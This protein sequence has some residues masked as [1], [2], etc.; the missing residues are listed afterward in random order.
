MPSPLCH[1]FPR[2]YAPMKHIETMPAALEY[3]PVRCKQ[4]KCNALLNPYW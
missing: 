2:S 1:S 4:S 3:E